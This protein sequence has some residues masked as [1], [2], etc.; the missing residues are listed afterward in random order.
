MKSF[1]ELDEVP[2]D[3]FRSGSVRR[4]ESFSKGKKRKIYISFIFIELL[5]LV[6]FLYGPPFYHIETVFFSNDLQATKQIKINIGG[7]NFLN[8]I[9]QIDAIFIQ[10]ENINRKIKLNGS[11]IIKGQSNSRSEILYTNQS[12]NY[13]VRYPK[14]SS[15]SNKLRLYT[16]KIVDFNSLDI[17]FILKDMNSDLSGFLLFTYRDCCHALIEELLRIIF[18]IIS[19]FSFIHFL[20]IDKK[21]TTTPIQLKFI[22]F[23]L[24]ILMLA[25]NPFFIFT[26]FTSSS[27]ISLIDTIFN[28]IF[29]TS[30][31]I[32][33]VVMMD[34]I[35]VK[36]ITKRW[37]VIELC[38]FIIT[39]LIVL[40]DVI[41]SF[42]DYISSVL[43]FLSLVMISIS[44][45]IVTYSFVM[46]KSKV[47]MEKSLLVS[48]T[49]ITV[50]FCF[51]F[52][53]YDS[54]KMSIA[55]GYKI[56]IFTFA[57]LA[58][59]LLL[60]AYLNN[61]VNANL[62]DDDEKSFDI[63]DLKEKM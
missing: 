63:P 19:I 40:F 54:F 26:Y 35:N 50:F 44:A 16:T 1:E 4:L 2:I 13:L 39:G 51:C 9:I 53:Y 14:S 3:Q 11:L 43:D 33:I 36:E 17:D 60:I 10:N 32:T 28:V 6:S 58:V 57:S 61:P 8:D 52:E 12:T 29:V 18:F 48:L 37:F 46:F 23:D 22:Q 47:S 5:I 62:C 21:S 42:G 24:L 38:P 25:S 45:V 56:Q 27:L 59:Y 15:L 34:I 41:L 55:Q 30:I 31:V 20:H 7:F 49:I